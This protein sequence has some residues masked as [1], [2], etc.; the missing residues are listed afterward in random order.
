[1]DTHDYDLRDT[2]WKKLR[3]WLF[4]SE[5]RIH[6]GRH[7]YTEEGCYDGCYQKTTHWETK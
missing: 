5:L 6:N 1:M 3:C 7:R 4:H 2:F